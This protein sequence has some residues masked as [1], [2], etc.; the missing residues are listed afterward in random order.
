[1]FLKRP[2]FHASKICLLAA[3]LLQIFSPF[4]HFHFDEHAHDH[5]PEA[6]AKKAFTEEET[7]HCAL[8]ESLAF[9][10]TLAAFAP[11]AFIWE[12]AS[13][14]AFVGVRPEKCFHS[15]SVV[16]VFSRGPPALS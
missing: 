8:C 11:K 10:K 7:D 14:Q 4:F 13:L 12:A 16:F 3:F 6:V 9:V 15:I 2:F 5:E 1:M